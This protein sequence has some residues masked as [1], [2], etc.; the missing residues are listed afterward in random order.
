[1]LTLIYCKHYILNC[2]TLQQFCMPNGLPAI[3]PGFTMAKAPVFHAIKVI[4]LD[5]QNCCSEDI[6]YTVP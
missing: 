4:V 2:L 6:L 5:L 3:R 1:M